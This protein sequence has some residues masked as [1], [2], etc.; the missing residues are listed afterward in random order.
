M[1]E[2]DSNLNDELQLKNW[3]NA[4]NVCDATMSINKNGLE[5]KEESS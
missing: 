1:S 4:I 5:K 2:T 3:T